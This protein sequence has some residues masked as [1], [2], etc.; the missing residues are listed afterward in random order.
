MCD[1]VVY[2]RVHCDMTRGSV[3]WYY[4]I[5]CRGNVESGCVI[6]PHAFLFVEV[7]V[8]CV[9]CNRKVREGEL[10]EEDERVRRIIYADEPPLPPQ[11]DDDEPQTPEVQHL[12]HSDDGSGGGSSSDSSSEDDFSPVQAQLQALL[13]GVHQAVRGSRRCV[14]PGPRSCALRRV[15][16]G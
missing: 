16:N 8:W 3:R 4:G 13:Q 1:G 12:D 14:R 7:R 5:W 10:E 15:A 9:S 11:L 2:W 6:E